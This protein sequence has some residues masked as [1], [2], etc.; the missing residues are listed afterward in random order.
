MSRQRKHPF[1]KGSD[2]VEE[3]PQNPPASHSILFVFGILGV[4]TLSYLS[5]G[6]VNR[7]VTSLFNP[8]VPEVIYHPAPPPPVPPV[9]NLGYASYRGLINNSVPDVVSWLDQGM[10]EHSQAENWTWRPVIDGTLF[11]DYPSKLAREKEV[12]IDIIVG[13]TTHDTVTAGLGTGS[14]SE[15]ARATYPKLTIADAQMLEKMYLD[16]GV[17]PQNVVG[18]GLGE[19]GFRCGMYMAGGRYGNRVYSY[20]FDE[21]DP[22][23]LE[24]AGHSA[25]NWILFEGTR[26]GANGTNTFNPLTPAQRA[27]SD[28]TI[29]YMVAFA[30]AGDPNSPRP[31]SMLSNTSVLP[32]PLW[33][34]HTSG[35]RMVFRAE[36]G[37]TRTRGVEGGSYVEEFDKEEVER[38]SQM[39]PSSSVPAK[40]AMWSLPTP[41]P[42]LSEL[43]ALAASHEYSSPSSSSSSLSRTNDS[44]KRV[45]RDYAAFSPSRFTTF[46]SS[47]RAISDLGLTKLKAELIVAARQMGTTGV[48]AW[49]GLYL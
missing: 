4:A 22:A 20:R 23:N 1:S 13:H 25:D 48:G 9:V 30:S 40:S 47:V 38:Y 11:P 16:A 43:S 46:I 10:A 17:E 34:R 32:S 27:L 7:F 28:E 42:S 29:A 39:K 19:A 49:L 35:K 37:G 12:D 6:Y 26:S 3:K 44:N 14:F 2:A 5:H 41:P 8:P 18:F 45:I 31:R 36:S 15:I 21:P 24:N 33:P